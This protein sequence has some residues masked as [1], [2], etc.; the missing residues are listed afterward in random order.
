ME[1]QDRLQKILINVGHMQAKLAEMRRENEALRKANKFL[2][3]E[4]ES[5]GS[6]HVEK[7]Y[8]SK[9]EDCGIS[10]TELFALKKEVKGYIAD[11]DKSITWLKQL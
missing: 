5:G 7:A 4:A 9:K 1:V 3:L 10:K 8:T 11:I 6:A 2:K